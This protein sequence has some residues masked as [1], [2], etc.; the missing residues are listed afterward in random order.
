MGGALTPTGGGQTLLPT[1]TLGMHR[2]GTSIVSRLVN[3][4]GVELG[5]EAAI[6][7]PG[8]DN[9]KGYWEHRGIVGINDEILERFGGRWD[10][11]PALTEA[12]AHDPRLDDLR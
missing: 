3:L 4:L 12:W 6:S 5:P 1:C 9:P 11:V 8:A 7:R 2:S 10:E